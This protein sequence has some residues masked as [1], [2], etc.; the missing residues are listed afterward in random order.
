MKDCIKVQVKKKEVVVLRTGPR[1]NLKLGTFTLQS[2][3]DGI[4][5]YEK[6]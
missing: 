2:C 1:Q 6:A 3:N 4:E 5:M